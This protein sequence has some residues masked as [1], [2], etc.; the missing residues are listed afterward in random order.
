MSLRFIDK[1]GLIA[2]AQG[3]DSAQPDYKLESFPVRLSGVEAL[4]DSNL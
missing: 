1:P 4:C 3:F 2:V